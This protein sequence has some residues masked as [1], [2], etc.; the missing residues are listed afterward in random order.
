MKKLALALLLS[1]LMILPAQGAALEPAQAL[2]P[3]TAI[4]TV[5]P[6]TLAQPLAPVLHGMLLAMGNHG[7]TAFDAGD[8][9]LT[10]EALY[11]SLSLY[12][13]IDERSEYL[14]GDLLLLSEEVADFAGALSLSPAAMGPLPRELTDR[15]TYL[16]E[17]DAYRLVCGSDGLSELQVR[18]ARWEDG[19]LVVEG[20]LTDMVEGCDIYA[21]RA[22]LQPSERMFGAVVTGLSLL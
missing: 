2:A 5:E 17:L 15:M 18:S 11:N 14:D 6:L 13:Q 4:S 22:V 1:A 21:F 20:A 7:C 8:P 16:P 9:L 19:G 10:W 3:D 12:G